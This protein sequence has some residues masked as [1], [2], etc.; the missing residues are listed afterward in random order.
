[1]TAITL[2]NADDSARVTLADGSL[3]VVD[4]DGIVYL[5]LDPSGQAS[6]VINPYFF[7]THGEDQ[8]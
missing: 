5:F 4:G 2:E 8:E 7:V 1:M 6:A 3:I